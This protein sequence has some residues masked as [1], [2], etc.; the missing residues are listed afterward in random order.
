MKLEWGVGVSIELL[1]IFE[2]KA[3]LADNQDAG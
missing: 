3:E 2:R 1:L